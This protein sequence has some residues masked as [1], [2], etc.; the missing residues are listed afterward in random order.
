MEHLSK[1]GSGTFRVACLKARSEDVLHAELHEAG[2]TCYF[3]ESHAITDS[4][5]F[6]EELCHG[7]HLSHP[8][9]VKLTSWDAAA[10][11]LWQRIM[12]QPQSRV[13][14]VWWD[15]HLLLDG[16]LQL[17]L[18]CLEFLQGV[19]EVTE[20]QAESLDCHPVLLRVV[21]LGEGPNFHPWKN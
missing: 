20:H 10:D 16:R 3:L 4:D 21:L 2:F 6:L 1:H 12:E 9:G 8:P 15:A 11:L 7:C 13:A 19:G 17:L 5:S 14:I 18:D